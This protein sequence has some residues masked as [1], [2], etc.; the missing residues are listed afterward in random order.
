MTPF[1]KTRAS[2]LSAT[3]FI[4]LATFSS[5]RTANASSNFPAALKT[6]L[7]AYFPGQTY[8]VPLC[9]ACHNTTAGGPG[10]L[11]KF[12]KNWENQG[13]LLPVFADRLTKEL[14]DYLT[15]APGPNDPQV[16]GKW[17]SDGDGVSDEEELKNFSSPA[18]AGPVAFCTDLTY[19]CGARIASAPPPIDKVGLFSAGLVVLG[20]TLLRR[21]RR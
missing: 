20:L 7:E 4:G 13:L 11:N 1:A 8:C 3:L 19:G 5:P 10:D 15:K 14:S 21:R 12:A 18:L 16:G 9:T 17:D 6:A 2:L